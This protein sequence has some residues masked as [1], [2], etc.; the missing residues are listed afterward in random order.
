MSSHTAIGEV[1]ILSQKAD[2]CKR[3]PSSGR[4]KIF[5]WMSRKTKKL[6]FAICQSQSWNNALRQYDIQKHPGSHLP[7]AICHL[8][9]AICHLPFA[10]CHLPF[11]ICHLPFAIRHLPFA[12]PHSPF[13]ILHSPFAICHCGILQYDNM[14]SENIWVFI[15]LPIS[16]SQFAMMEYCCSLT[17]CIW[18]TEYSL[19]PGHL[20]NSIPQ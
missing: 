13:P 11:A 15:S 10:I 2:L 16:Q 6:P 20:S 17:I 1:G 9:F 8:L 3:N 14:R 12:I 7:F 19:H 18:H 4:Q 5:P